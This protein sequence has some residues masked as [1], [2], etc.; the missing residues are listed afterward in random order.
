MRGAWDNTEL[1]CETQLIDCSLS[2]NNGTMF[3]L[4]ARSVN[5]LN[6]PAQNLSV[7]KCVSSSKYICVL[8]N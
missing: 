7:V 4:S 2:N 6:L 5:N 3:N 1:V 8:K